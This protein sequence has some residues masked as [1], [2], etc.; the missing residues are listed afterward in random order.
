MNWNS[1]RRLAGLIVLCMSF[2]GAAAAQEAVSQ[3]T[4]AGH[5]LDQQGAA[6]PGALVTVRQVDT[7]SSSEA[8]ADTEGRFRFPYLRIG[9][10]E[11]RAKLTGF[12]EHARTLV[13]RIRLRHPDSARG[14]RTRG[15]GYRDG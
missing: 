9:T 14:W 10:Y 7:N 13:L 5:V 8:V 2:T 4:I 1:C 6:V 15:R 12:R 3:G 11:L